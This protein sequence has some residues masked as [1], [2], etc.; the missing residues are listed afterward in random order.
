M[1]ASIFSGGSCLWYSQLSVLSMDSSSGVMWFGPDVDRMGRG[2][3]RLSIRSRIK[4]MLCISMSSS[5]FCSS[6]TKKASSKKELLG[7]LRPSSSSGCVLIP[8]LASV[9]P[10]PAT[11]VFTLSPA[12]KADPVAASGTRWSACDSTLSLSQDFELGCCSISPSGGSVALGKVAFFMK[13]VYG[14][15]ARL[16]LG[17]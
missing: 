2:I 15:R 17:D 3:R 9:I 5:S 8:S 16:L 13:K 10:L 12:V 14:V 6:L 11:R 4:A 1:V 7:L